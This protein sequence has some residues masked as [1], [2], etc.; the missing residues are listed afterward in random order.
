MLT[1]T[2]TPKQTKMKKIMEF[3][4]LNTEI[5]MLIAILFIAILCNTTNDI[6]RDKLDRISSHD[7]T[8][9]SNYN[10]THK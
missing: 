8:L 1:I 6:Q 9:I 5:L 2:E 7:S 3:I 4:W 10:L